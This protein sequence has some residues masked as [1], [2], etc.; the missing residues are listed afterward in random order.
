LYG[1]FMSEKLAVDKPLGRSFIF[2]LALAF[3]GTSMLDVLASLFLVDLSK[4]FMGSTSLVSIAIVSQ[5]VTISSITAV[6]FGILNGFLS[7]KVN[8]K[9]LLLF[10]ALCIVVG[11]L[12]CFFAPS[13]LFLEIF[14]PFDG[15]GT[16]VVGAMAFTLIGESLPLEKRANAIGWVTA[17][18]IFSSGIGFAWA[19]FIGTIAG[20][21]S[22]LLWYV[23][24]ISF[25]AL[26]LAYL[27]VP[28]KAKQQIVPNQKNYVGSFKEVLLNKSAAACLFGNM[29]ITAAGVWSFFAATFWRKQFSVPLQMV[30]L[31]TLVV[32][33]VYAVG[34]IIGGHVVNKSGRKRLV[35]SSWAIRG[36]MIASIVFMP[37]FW[38]A[39][40]MS[41]LATFIGGIAITSA[42]IL[43][44]EQ[45][46]RARGTMM[47]LSGV[48][49]SIGASLGVS[50]G[51]LALSQS[52]FQLLGTV[53]GVF[54]VISALIIYL[55]A[56]DP[57]KT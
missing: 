15:I 23:I 50:V 11:A 19:G 18:A 28:S 12:G 4:A 54:G 32:V 27:R 29:L 57:Y 8:H 31:I 6:V 38:S 1:C 9:I 34:S 16:I 10:G 5:I 35:V 7:V 36:V 51:G 30:G 13:L 37:T 56:K 45:A 44:I 40:I 33:L 41:A 55:L 17:A 52:G 46:P 26:T 39:L 49:G 25:I 21:R 47:S 42:N 48:F 24:P 20:W 2:S 43:N 14:Y 53:F 3:F 22:Y